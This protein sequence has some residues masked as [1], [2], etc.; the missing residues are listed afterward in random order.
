VRVTRD[1]KPNPRRAS[2]RVW[3]WVGCVALAFALGMTVTTWEPTRRLGTSLGHFVRMPRATWEAWRIRN[4]LPSVELSLKFVVYEQ[5]QAAQARLMRDGA[6]G[7]PE[8]CVMAEVTAGPSPVL[9]LVCP[10]YVEGGLEMHRPP[11]T[12]H[13]Q[14]EQSPLGMRIASLVPATADSVLSTGYL[15]T[16]SD[17]GFRVPERTYV[18]VVVNGSP[19][20]VYAMESHP[21]DVF[22]GDEGV[23]ADSVWIAFDGAALSGAPDA[24]P[25]V[26]FAYA[27]P[28]LRP[29]G[30]LGP[31]H[32][33]DLPPESP[34]GTAPETAAAGAL[35]AALE[36]GDLVPSSVLDPEAVGQLV[37]ATALWH[38]VRALDWQTLG[39]LY[40][41]GS[42]Q[43][44]PWVSSATPNP[45]SPLPAAFTDDPAIQRATVRW[46]ATYSDPAAVDLGRLE[47]LYGALGGTPGGLRARLAQHQAAMRA[48]IAPART[49][50][51]ALSTETA[52]IRLELQ[53]VAPFPVEV[54]GI[55]F[56]ARGIVDLS[57]A[58]IAEGS[59]VLADT[60]TVILRARV[61]ADPVRAMVSIPLAALPEGVNIG[62]GA[63]LVV[64]R[65]LD[66]PEVARLPVDV[67]TGVGR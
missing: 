40:D 64:T 67:G 18:H 54:L 8:E 9:A 1:V 25:E 43:L 45:R 15:E 49:L 32:A 33:A 66:G 57:P 24:A 7:G 19:W 28:V 36:R 35:L 30:A 50:F 14:G 5:W 12:L 39:F 3:R 58:W 63:V 10:L 56:G 13:V 41:P 53:A 47:G 60:Q 61:G 22:A 62:Q 21:G 23:A 48:M 38:G 20:G 51:A 34:A 27:R 6:S 16:L 55:D 31:L 44:T 17:A 4:R 59:A 46:M 52:G 2:F 37:A 42:G 65:V 29:V 11:F 26:S